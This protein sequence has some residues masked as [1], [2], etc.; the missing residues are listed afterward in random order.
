[1]KELAAD[2]ECDMAVEE[3]INFDVETCS[4]LQAINA[5]RVDWRVSSLRNCV[6]EYPQEESGE[7]SAKVASDSDDED[8]FGE[9]FAEIEVSREEALSLIDKIVN[10]KGL[11]KEERDSLVSLKEKLEIIKINSKMQK[12]IKDYFK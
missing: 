7:D 9:E 4:S 3:Y 2:S 5:D 10:L 8:D 12:S 11:N 6:A 1:M